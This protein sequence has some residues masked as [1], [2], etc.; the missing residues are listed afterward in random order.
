MAKKTLKGTTAEDWL[1]HKVEFR[2]NDKDYSVPIKSNLVLDDLSVG[3][4]KDYLNEI[5]GRLSYWK[6]FLIPVERELVKLEEEYEIWFQ[7]VYM[8]VDAEY[9]KKTE[10]WKKS[11][12]MLDNVDEY[13]TR[14][15]AIHDLRDINKKVNVI[16]TGYNTQTWTLREIARLT[17]GELSNIEIRGRGN[18]SDIK[19]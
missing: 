14:R 12:V 19:G 3:E 4:I 10:G 18:L 1:A 13:R 9:G 7:K 16:I 6:S 5:P 11:R 2:Y 17:Y 15:A 8:D